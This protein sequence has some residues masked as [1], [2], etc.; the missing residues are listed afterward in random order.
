MAWLHRIDDDNR[1]GL[2]GNNRY[3]NY[4]NAVRGMAFPGLRLIIKWMKM[5]VMRFT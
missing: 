1:S 4:G 2:N 3:L 5:I